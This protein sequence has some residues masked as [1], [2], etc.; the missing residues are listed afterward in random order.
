MDD[1]YYE[2]VLKHCNSNVYTY[3]KNENATVH[4]NRET[5]EME[6]FANKTVVENVEDDA[7]EISLEKARM[8][9]SKYDIGDVVPVPVEDLP[10]WLKAGYD[11]SDGMPAAGH[12]KEMPVHAAEPTGEWDA[13]RERMR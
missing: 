11:R 1:K 7:L 9:S 3:G 2:T 13:G 5:G 10:M 4:M 12:R 8:I 6:V